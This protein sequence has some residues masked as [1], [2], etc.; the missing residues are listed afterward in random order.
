MMMEKTRPKIT[1]LSNTPAYDMP[2]EYFRYA[3]ADHFWIQWRFKILQKLLPPQFLA[4]EV[5]EIGCGNGVAKDFIEQHYGAAVFGC[6]L[7]QEGLEFASPGRGGLYF[8]D[9]YDQ[10]PQWQGKFN[11][12]VLLD[13][14]EH[15][16]SPVPFL[17][18]VGHHL[19]KGGGLVINVP[20]LPF[21]YGKY[22]A[23]QGH[24]KRYTPE[25]IREE[26][27]QAGYDVVSISYWGS[28]FIPIVLLRKMLQAKTPDQKVMEQGFKP[29]SE[30]MNRLMKIFMKL[31]LAVWNGKLPG[32]S[33]MA[34]GRKK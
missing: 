11:A 33:L 24:V 21:L 20:A 18:V 2:G 17:K 4:G 32:T 27:D 28:T 5:L 7:S 1:V 34:I 8:Y 14:L 23:V 10:R 15:I 9:I 16:E 25:K 19:T 30:F 22:D 3:T 26:F 13:V 31:E 12:A 29:S 6:D